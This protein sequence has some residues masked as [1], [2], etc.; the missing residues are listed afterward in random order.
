LTI[1]V[2][3]CITGDDV[4][5]AIGQCVHPIFGDPVRVV[6]VRQ[7]YTVQ[8]LSVDTMPWRKVFFPKKA[9]LCYAWRMCLFTTLLLTL[10]VLLTLFSQVSR[11]LHIF[12]RRLTYSAI[13][14]SPCCALIVCSF[15][16][17]SM[18]SHDVVNVA[19]VNLEDEG[20]GIHLEV[21]LI[22]TSTTSWP[23]CTPVPEG[24]RFLHCAALS[25]IPVSAGWS[26]KDSF[27][28]WQSSTQSKA[29]VGS[30]V[31]VEVENVTIWFA[32]VVVLYQRVVS[33]TLV[34]W[35]HRDLAPHPFLDKEVHVVIV[36]KL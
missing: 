20:I 25:G 3:C 32:W 8:A 6:E 33:P 24:R 5:V 10:V 22:L 27:R 26:V 30:V 36:Q 35:Y 23:L 9:S 7:P 2:R 4:F 15:I 16:Y 29:L 14:H 13:G 34:L 21:L 28:L 19:C 1:G 31:P 11:T 17:M 12:G 18:H